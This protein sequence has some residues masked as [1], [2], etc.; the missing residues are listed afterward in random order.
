MSRPGEHVIQFFALPPEVRRVI[1]ATNVIESLRMQRA[2]FGF[3]MPIAIRMR[4][5][6]MAPLYLVCLC[7]GATGLEP[8]SGKP[9][10]HQIA[11][12]LPRRLPPQQN[13]GRRSV[14]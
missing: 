10:S 11:F 2:Q 12:G 1:Y 6:S 5:T 3:N 13:A 14:I 9:V 7:A 8:E 4:F